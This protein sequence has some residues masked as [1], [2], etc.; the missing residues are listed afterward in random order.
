MVP[1]VAT[2]IGLSLGGAALSAL[3]GLF[4]GASGGSASL[5][6]GAIKSAMSDYMAQINAA[7]STGRANVAAAGSGMKKEVAKY[8]KEYQS[9][10][11]EETKQFWKGL[12]IHNDGLIA[13]ATALVD[14]FNGDI[15]QAL[16]VLKDT[17]GKLNEGYSEDMSS[18]INSYTDINNL[19]DQS[20]ADDSRV[21]TDKFLERK[22]VAQQ[23]FLTGANAE[24][25]SAKAESMA[26]GD[27]FKGE[28]DSALADYSKVANQSPDFLA[29]VTRSADMLSKAAQQTRLDLLQRADPRMWELSTIAD[30]NTEALMSGKISADVQANLARS[31]AF[32]AL[33]GGFGAG[34]EMG[35][36]LQ[37]RDL[38]LTSLDLQQQGAAQ[39]DA[40]RRLNYETRV[41]GTEVNPFDV[42]RQMQDAAGNLLSSRIG[43][44][45]SDRNQ[46]LGAVQDA[47]QQ[48]LGNMDSIFSS[49]W[50]AANALRE[51]DMTLAG[52]R[53]DQ[54]RDT[55][56]RATG[57]RIG[58]TQDMYNNSW[59]LADTI[60][61]AQVGKAG[62]TFSTGTSLASDI[63]KTNVG[64]TG[65]VFDTRV[66][67]GGQIY[68]T[69]SDAAV[70][71]AQM[72]AAYEQA[73]LQAQS[74]AAGN[75]AGTMA[76]IPMQQMANSQ[77]RGAQTA[78]MWGSA[79]S[80]GASLAGSFLGSGMFQSAPRTP[81]GGSGGA[82]GAG[83]K[84]SFM[85]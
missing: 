13:S 53:S 75:V 58:A 74:T 49:D 37:A 71:A 48:R 56:L 52:T 8:S 45:E 9:L 59:G 14:T 1:G 73:A 18:E 26:L 64:G 50:N 21:A 6:T 30:N 17:T 42:S 77:A 76:N 5:N 38:G 28:T 4:G 34:G 82:V 72:A 78:Q 80:A 62:Q 63:Y 31:G 16:E 46:R 12:G 79:L 55:A 33:S 35:R 66:G 20:L 44:A 70:Q 19:I 54:R 23:R 67:V 36:N 69:R 27:R 39:Y 24:I 11:D 29:E 25:D 10:T 40:Q 3:P 22:D 81:Y 85:S 57:M 68:S 60:F 51:Q 32:K 15:D 43:V 41:A 47:S 7:I 61:N 84:P 2:A 65:K 83:F